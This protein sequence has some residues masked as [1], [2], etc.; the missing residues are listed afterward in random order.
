[1]RIKIGSHSTLRGRVIQNELLC[2]E[3]IVGTYEKC[4]RKKYGLILDFAF[5]FVG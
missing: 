3:H 4:L 2:E 5:I 1:M